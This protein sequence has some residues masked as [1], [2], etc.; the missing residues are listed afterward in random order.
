MGTAASTH[1]AQVKRKAVT[2]A[3]F[4]KLLGGDFNSWFTLC[5]S[6]AD[7]KRESGSHVAPVTFNLAIH[8]GEKLDDAATKINSILRGKIEKRKNHDTIEQARLVE[9]HNMYHHAPKLLSNI[10]SHGSLFVWLFGA[11]VWMVSENR[12]SKNWMT[13]YNTRALCWSKSL[14]YLGLFVLCAMLR[15]CCCVWRNLA[16]AL[17]LFKAGWH[18]RKSWH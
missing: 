15:V 6:H 9:I 13:S 4:M 7:A 10:C 12:R 8:G 3:K 1:S 17:T 14:C 5:M 2:A 18:L 16:N 11:G